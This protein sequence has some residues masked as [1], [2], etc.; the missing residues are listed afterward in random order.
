MRK[1]AAFILIA[2]FICLSFAACSG[3]QSGG[4]GSQAIVVNNQ[5]VGR[6]DAPIEITF[7]PDPGHW[8]S[9]TDAG[10]A[11]Y[12]EKKARAWAEAHPDVKIVPVAQSVNINDSMGKLLIQ[13]A[14]GNAPDFAE[15]D[16]FVLPNFKQY[17]QPLDD[18]LAEKGID[19]ASW[20]PFAQEGVT[21][22]GKFVALWHT[23]DVRVLYYN[24]ALVPNPPTTWEELFRIGQELKGQGYTPLLYPAGRNETT[25]CD[26]LPWFWSQGGSLVDGSGNPIFDQGNNRNFLL[27]TLAFLKQTIDT[28][29][30]PARVTTFGTDSDMNNE[31]VAG[32][33]AMFVGGSWLSS[34]LRTILGDKEFSDTWGLAQ[35]PMPAGGKRVSTAGGW[36][37]GVFTKDDQKRK[38]AADFAISCYIDDSAMDEYSSISGQLPCRSTIYEK[39]EHFKNDPVLVA[40][41]NELEFARVRPGVE[42]YPTI[43]QEFQVAISD[44]I[45]GAATPEAALRT[46][47]QNIQK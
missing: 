35:I 31:V 20:F 46:M 6:A 25:S 15:V 42:I 32:K 13:A 39:S 11:S 34:Q 7:Q 38:L 37:V 14:D 29:I 28:G 40:Y 45:T 12:F 23:T 33:V 36:T 9:S 22:N 8:L 3:K 10:V 41:A 47:S 16:S 21:Y 5:L 18:V 17:L 27:N 2:V 26:I 24:K 30:S 43:S 44:V 19:K 1:H 4:S